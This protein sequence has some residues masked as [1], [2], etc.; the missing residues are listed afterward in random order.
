M[1][2]DRIQ[3]RVGRSSSKIHRQRRI[4]AITTIL[5]TLIVGGHR[6]ASSVPANRRG[7][8]TNDSPESTQ[9]AEGG[10]GAGEFPTPSAPAI[11]ATTWSRSPG[12]STLPRRLMDPCRREFTTSNL[13]SA[14]SN[15]ALLAVSMAIFLMSTFHFPSFFP[16]YAISTVIDSIWS[17]AILI[18]LTA[19]SIPCLLTSILVAI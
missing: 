7:R 19:T 18:P 5:E 11:C 12:K 3:N 6:I 13:M 16:R 17:W 2:S 8:A 4:I 9:G 1:N 15:L 14:P 10:D